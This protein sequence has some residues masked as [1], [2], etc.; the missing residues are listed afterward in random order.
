MRF[1]NS[2]LNAIFNCPMSYHLRYDL[3]IN[4]V[5]KS[6]ALDLGSAIHW[7]IEHN[8]DN[9]NEYYESESSRKVL[10]SKRDEQALAEV[11]VKYYIDN[12]DEILK[13][14]LKDV[15]IEERFHELEIVCKLE[16]K[17]EIEGSNEF[18]GIIDYLLY[19]NKGFI[20]I[21]YKT[22]SDIPKYEKYLQQLLCYCMLINGEFP[23]I[24][25][26]KIAV[27]NFLK[28]KTKR[29]PNETIENYKRRLRNEYI[30]DNIFVNIY[31]GE[32]ILQ[33]KIESYKNNLSKQCDVALQIVQFCNRFNNYYIN[34]NT[35]NDYGGNVYKPLFDKQKDAYV[36][37]T[38]KD[39]WVDDNDKIID[40]RYMLP[41]DIDAIYDGMI[42]CRYKDFLI[43]NKDILEK[44]K[45]LLEVKNHMKNINLKF[46]EG[47]IDIYYKIYQ[48]ERNKENEK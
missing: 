14:L 41:I 46:E 7:G 30:D 1:S 48:E 16:S 15:I 9:L 31:N 4:P 34:Y 42:I 35:V 45:S 44:N 43:F 18:V 3:G 32:L 29:K 25:I 24:P 28:S 37:Y 23:G 39:K 33:E 5:V 27:V 6:K 22:S 13:N 12:E 20:I 11:I 26:Y 38:V 10:E 36:M 17:I 40:T 47:M 8:T 21:D 2:K 19:T